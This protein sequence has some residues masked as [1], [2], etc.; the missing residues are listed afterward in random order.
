MYSWC[1]E[2]AFTVPMRGP[3]TCRLMS[4]VGLSLPPTPTLV[5]KLEAGKVH[6]HEIH[7]DDAGLPVHPV[8]AILGGTPA[9]NGQALKAL[10]AGA[11][12]AYRDAVLFNAAAALVIAGVAA[13]LPEGVERARASLDSGAARARAE[14]LARITTEATQ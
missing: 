5:A 1:T 2:S 13:T 7:P 9:E 11:P 14:A 8:E 12:G 4:Y 3:E 10:L 6:E